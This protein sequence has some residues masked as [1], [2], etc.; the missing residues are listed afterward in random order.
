MPNQEKTDLDIA[1]GTN[2]YDVALLFP[3]TAA[4]RCAQAE[5]RKWL[6]ISQ[7]TPHTTR[8]GHYL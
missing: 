1:E 4:S 3:S 2:T 5:I 6:L 8:V 7:H